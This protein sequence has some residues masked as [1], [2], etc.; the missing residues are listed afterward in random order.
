M[1]AANEP[2]FPTLGG[3][4][5]T[6]REWFAGMALQG[7]LGNS[8]FRGIEDIAAQQA[9]YLAAAMLATLSASE[10]EG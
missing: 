9:A 7:M 6:K 2:A 3:S 1:T 10:G 8:D 5:L 4:V